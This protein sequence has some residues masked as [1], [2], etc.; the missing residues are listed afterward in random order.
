MSNEEFFKASIVHL[1]LL[2][3]P[4]VALEIMAS[5]YGVGAVNLRVGMPKGHS[6]NV[7]CYVSS[8]KTIFVANSAILFNPHVLLH[9]FYHHLRTHNVEHRGTERYANKFA[10]DYI[11]AFQKFRLAFAQK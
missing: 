7:G 2:K 4:E 10:Q 6:K 11:D 9:E 1:I 3:K 5:F 8:E